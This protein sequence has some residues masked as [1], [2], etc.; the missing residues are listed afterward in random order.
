MARMFGSVSIKDFSLRAIVRVTCFLPRA[1]APPGAR[2]LPAVPASTAMVNQAVGG[3]S[4]VRPF[5]A[6]AAFRLFLVRRS[7]YPWCGLELA[8]LQQR[9]YRV[10]GFDRIDIQHENDVRIHRSA[11]A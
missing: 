5:D 4:R 3:H 6:R 2:I 7:E 11:R 10:H 9:Q 1:A 8:L